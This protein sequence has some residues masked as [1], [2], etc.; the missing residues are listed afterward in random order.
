[1]RRKRPACL[2]YPFLIFEAINS[3]S[4]NVFPPYKWRGEEAKFPQTVTRSD[5]PTVLGFRSNIHTFSVFG[6]NNAVIIW[7]YFCFARREIAAL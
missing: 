5:G 7:R 3:A 6:L 1:M 2:M 4:L